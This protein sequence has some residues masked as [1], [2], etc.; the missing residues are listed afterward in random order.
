MYKE[1]N[2]RWV[3]ILSVLKRIVIQTHEIWKAVVKFCYTTFS[4]KL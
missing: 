2:F 3:G 4:V 1:L